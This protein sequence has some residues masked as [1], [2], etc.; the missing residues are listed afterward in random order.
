MSTT[1]ACF[2]ITV[3]F[4]GIW[5]IVVH[6]RE[7]SKEEEKQKRKKALPKPNAGHNVHG[8]KEPSKP[9]DGSMR[10][11]EHRNAEANNSPV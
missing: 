3:V 8:T 4:V 10:L 6:F 9:E 2:G 11:R 7:K 5:A 1:A